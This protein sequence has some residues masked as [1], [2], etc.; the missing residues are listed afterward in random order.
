MAPYARSLVLFAI[1][2]LDA[3]GC[4]ASSGRT[5]FVE[6][7]ADN[8]GV[9]PLLDGG[10]FRTDGAEAALDPGSGGDL[11]VHDLRVLYRFA[12]KQRTLTTIG[13]FDCFGGLLE[14]TSDAGMRDIAIDKSGKAFGV[15]KLGTAVDGS[16]A[17]IVRL[18]TTNAHCEE[19]FAIP[20]NL[21]D[22]GGGL[23][24]WGLSFVPGATDDVLYGIEVAGAFIR[25]DVNA[26]TAVR[27]G[28][29]NGV[30][31]GAKGPWLTKGADIVSI[32]GDRTYSTA[33]RD[34][35]GDRL[36]ALDPLTGAVVQDIG[37][38][39]GKLF[40]GIAY[41]EGTLYGFSSQGRVYA[42]DTKTA[43]VTEIFAAPDGVLL[44]GAGVTTIAPT[45]PR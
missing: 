21:V 18:D 31:P 1:V 11:F 30:A 39:D 2:L 6:E 44:Q 29:L 14:A 9:P 20:P 38:L 34:P 37:P 43:A 5:G 45:A 8:G 3:L 41:W 32:K 19:V 42:V 23:E 40:G 35:S 28:G 10:A 27:V 24:M 33:Q 12:P 36:V 13:A 15:A 17:A 22:S 7:T 16:R 26:K 25:I 4:S